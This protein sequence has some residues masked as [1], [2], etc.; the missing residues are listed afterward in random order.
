MT[1]QVPESQQRWQLATAF[2]S[3]SSCMQQN[4]EGLRIA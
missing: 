4:E 3:S 1:D 2:K